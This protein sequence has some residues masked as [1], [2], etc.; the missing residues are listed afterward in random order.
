MPRKFD[1]EGTP[2]LFAPHSEG[3]LDEY[4]SGSHEQSIQAVAKDIIS[5]LS[6]SR[7]R[8]SGEVWYD[9]NYNQRR[10]KLTLMKFADTIIRADVT[11]K[12]IKSRLMKS[13][14]ENIKLKQRIEELE[15]KK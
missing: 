8:L 2:F 15:G 14:M 11:I 10:Y 13:E 12:N 7:D 6:E 9:F 1:T 5:C 4:F 3:E